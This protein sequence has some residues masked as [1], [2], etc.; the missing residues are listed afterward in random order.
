VLEQLPYASRTSNHFHHSRYGTS[1]GVVSHGPLPAVPIL[2]LPKD[3]V[4][5]L[6]DT[7]IGEESRNPFSEF[8]AGDWWMGLLS[9][10]NEA[11][12]AITLVKGA[13]SVPE[14]AKRLHQWIKSG[15]RKVKKSDVQESACQ[16]NYRSTKGRG[17]LILDSEPTLKELTEWLTATYTILEGDAENR[18]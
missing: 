14:V 1:F 13:S 4:T 16:L 8:S 9:L 3:V 10:T 17:Q 12:A 11:S 18:E 15:S 7:G 2:V 6:I 5:E